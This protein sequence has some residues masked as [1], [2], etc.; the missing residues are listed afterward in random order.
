MSQDDLNVEI[1]VVQRKLKELEKKA[2]EMRRQ[3]LK[4][5]VKEAQRSGNTDR[6]SRI[7]QI[8]HR[9]AARKRWRTVNRTTRKPRGRQVTSVKVPSQE[10]DEGF[11]EFK[12]EKGVFDAVAVGLSERFRLAFTAQCYSGQL[13]DDIGFVGDTECARQILE[14]TY[15]FPPDTDPATRLLLE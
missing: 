10:F 15:V 5:I 6:A 1:L 14:G 4:S 11:E 7:L 8:L 12:T 2:P 13:F 3:H 9:E